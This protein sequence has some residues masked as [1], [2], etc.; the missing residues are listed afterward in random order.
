[1]I[2]IYHHKNKVKEILDLE[3]NT[4]ISVVTESIVETMFLLSD[5]HT[6]K[7]I[8]WCNYELKTNL[9]VAILNTVF[10]HNLIMASYAV[11]DVV[12]NSKIGYVE[13]SV[14]INVKN[15]VRFSTWFMSTN[16][17]GINSSV[18]NKY[19]DLRNY[20]SFKLFLN[21][22]AKQGI[23][24]GLI[25]SSEPKLL[26]NKNQKTAN[27]LSE[28]VTLKELFSF[29]KSSY[30][31]RWL[32][33]LFFNLV[34]YEKIFPIVS[35]VSSFFIKLKIQKLLSF[36]DIKVQSIKEEIKKEAFSVD[37]LIPTLG[38]E[39]YLK[40]VLLDLN[41]QTFLPE[42][43]IIIEQNPDTTAVSSLDYLKD[44]WN[45]EI[46]H[47]FIHQ[48]GACNARNIGLSKV[49]SNFVFFADDDIR[50]KN[51]VL[52]ES[53]KEF[54]QFQSEAIVFSCLQKGQNPEF[55][56]TTL[57]TTFGS[58]TS[59]VKSS[60]VKKCSFKT[61]H[62]LG[63][64][65]DADFGMQLRNLGVTI[66]SVPT[67]QLLHLKA[68]V[69]GFRHKP[70]LAWECDQ[71]KPSPTIMAHHFK[72]YTKQQLLGYK[73]NLFIK[74]YRSKSQ[75]IKNPITYFYSMKKRWNLSV[76]WAQKLLKNEV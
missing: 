1:M 8:I 15:N 7:F 18:L 34:V 67:I 42:K 76:N 26:I 22:I 68:P 3:S 11:S 70:I 21:V 23:Q 27:D 48:L 30:K 5:L 4:T 35:F 10:H 25:C 71:P 58:G 37:V 19:K 61:E 52:E 39:K 38:R 50:F 63:Y 75:L 33:L 66:L 9:N 31:T 12:F 64:G 69:G 28:K 65:E 46:D 74:F 40:D 13:Q 2:I 24:K 43:V 29:V 6:N 20:K 32:F 49:N 55:L 36:D 57:A 47:T 72:H 73:T 60:F 54:N 16:V 41:K 14:F 59:L 45:F 17:G 44:K 56:T 62:E 53:F 51:D